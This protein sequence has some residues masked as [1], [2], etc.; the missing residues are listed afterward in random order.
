MLFIIIGLLV[1]TFIL[2]Y[3]YK[4]NKDHTTKAFKIGG[5][6][7]AAIF[8]LRTAPSLVSSLI[9]LIIV[10]VPFLQR[11]T[12][13]QSSK[14]KIEM[15]MQEARDVLGVTNDA[16]EEEIKTAYK[17]QMKKNHPDVGGSKY[18]AQKIISAKKTLIGK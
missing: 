6:I 9:N 8:L 18:L 12:N 7:T 2:H 4:K 10:L 11:H 5:L 3:F 16:S 15:T 14:V 17:E 1:T 13:E